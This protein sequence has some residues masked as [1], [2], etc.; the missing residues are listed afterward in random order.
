MS[1][2]LFQG[3]GRVHQNAGSGSAWVQ[4]MGV[5]ARRVE[6]TVSGAI[7]TIYKGWAEYGTEESADDWLIVKLVLD[8]ASGLTVTNGVAGGQS[9]KFNFSW[10]NR[11]GHSYS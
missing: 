9:N 5:Y 7:T 4:Q 3:K 1:S 8:E 2:V 11:T 6:L 10:T